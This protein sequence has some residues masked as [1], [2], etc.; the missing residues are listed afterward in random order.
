MPT[1]TPD[2]ARVD[3]LRAAARRSWDHGQPNHPKD[4]LRVALPGHGTE[5]A[6]ALDVAAAARLTGRDPRMLTAT[7]G[8]AWANVARVRAHL[9]RWAECT[10]PEIPAISG[11]Q[12]CVFGL[13]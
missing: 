5:P 7:G 4:A 11:L 9:R 2:P 12:N 3:Q 13:H 1:V 10:S 8:L 6:T